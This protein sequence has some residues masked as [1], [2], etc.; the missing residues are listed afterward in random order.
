MKQTILV[1]FL[2]LFVLPTFGQTFKT[3]DA[4]TTF[5]IG[6]IKAA[7]SEQ[8]NKLMVDFVPPANVGQDD[9]QK[10]DLAQGDEILYINGKRVKTI[11]A[12]KEGYNSIKT[13][14]E[15]KLGV[16]RDEK[17][18]IVSFQKNDEAQKGHV[19]M[20]S[21]TIGEGGKVETKTLTPKD[22]KVIIN[23]EEIDVDSLEK[24]GV[25]KMKTNKKE[26]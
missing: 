25:I 16:K 9:A 11:D 13:G 24:Q 22:G 10:V 19:M 14:E 12:L 23:G 15:V 2:S 4:G 17:R 20:M 18:F 3:F 6:E 1:I 7:I 26:K 21:K 5:F 8:E